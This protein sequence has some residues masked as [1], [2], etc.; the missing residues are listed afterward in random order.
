LV[1]TKEEFSKSAEPGEAGAK[2][3]GGRSVSSPRLVMEAIMRGI[4]AGRFVPGQRLIE[5]DLT[6]ELKVSRGPV[7]EAFKR[8]AGEGVLTLNRHRGAY[9]RALSREGVRDTLQ[10]LEVITSLAAKLAAR[11]I[12]EGDNRERFQE[13]YDRLMAHAS[14]G[15]TL[16]FLAER[17]RFYDTISQIAGNRELHRIMPHMQISL[18]R[19]QFQSFI[20]GKQHQYQIQELKAIA[21]AILAGDAKRA[22]RASKTHLRRRRVSLVNLPDEAYA[23]AES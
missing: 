23:A 7:R 8:L 5:A 9:I 20:T 12:D 15:E 11:H 16:Q 19:L 4:D 10:V 14:H 3:S 18:L 21:E 1:Q 2:K 17:R 13:A 22:E 6:R